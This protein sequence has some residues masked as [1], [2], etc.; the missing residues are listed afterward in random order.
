LNWGILARPVGGGERGLHTAELRAPGQWQGLAAFHSDS[1]SICVWLARVLRTFLRVEPRTTTLVI[2]V[3][4][5]SRF[6]S[7]AAFLLPLKVLLL[8]GSHGVPR[9]FRA[10]VDADSKL[11]WMI[12]LSIAAAGLFLA[13]RFLHAY[14]KKLSSVGSHEVVKRANQL[15]WLINQNRV[16]RRHFQTITDL[17]ADLV[18]ASVAITIIAII[19]P[20][21][22]IGLAVVLTFEYALTAILLERPAPNELVQRIKEKP[23]VYIE[24]LY[25]A[26]FWLA[27]IGILAPFL[28]GLGGNTLLAILSF[29]LVRLALKDLASSV[30]A[31][32]RL[33]SKKRLIDALMFPT[34]RWQRA[35]PKIRRDFHI[36]FEKKAHLATLDN[37]LRGLES[38]RQTS[39]RWQD[40]AIA[41][42]STFILSFGPEGPYYQEQVFPDHRTHLLKNEGVLFNHIPRDLL[43]APEVFQ[44]FSHGPFQCR[45]CDYGL[46]LP[47]SAAVWNTQYSELLEYIWSLKPPRNLVQV[48]RKSHLFFYECLTED[49]VA[50]L[51]VAVDNE[52]EEAVLRTFDASLPTIRSTL[53][54]FP[55]YISNRDLVRSNT[56]LRSDGGMFI[57]TWGRWSLQPLGTS[58]PPKLSRA[59][60][61][62]MLGRIRQRRPDI[63]DMFGPD[64]LQLVAACRQLAERLNAT[65]YAAALRALPAIL[66][67]PVLSVESSRTLNDAKK[68]GSKRPNGRGRRRRDTGVLPEVLVH[69]AESDSEKDSVRVKA[70][71]EQAGRGARLRHALVERREEA[72]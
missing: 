43:H 39:V 52:Q 57:M 32:A 64:H 67:N 51:R 56:A 53:S 9:Y 30:E 68:G 22:V 55:L 34:H 61:S 37:A 35:E 1:M 7:L 11:S 2:A 28:F 21:F 16:A 59:K 69:A 18:T 17:C 27:F 33:A 65:Q 62:D 4:V 19:N 6:T 44:Q 29:V 31:I 40:S 25:T 20:L 63:P 48:F 14:A 71:R 46:G 26:N 45:I 41:G 58:L 42:V 54:A 24:N 3:T 12:G 38:H 15:E 60:L 49:L 36:L 50:K 5:L 72:N 8:A 47:I 23:D 13:T 10:I 66:N 70:S